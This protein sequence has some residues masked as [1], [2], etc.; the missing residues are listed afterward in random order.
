MRETGR[1]PEHLLALVRQRDADPFAEGRRASS[2]V[3]GHVE[4]APRRGPDELSLRLLDLIVQ[5]AQ[6]PA[7]RVAVVVLHERDVEPRFA[8]VALIPGFE[9]ETPLVAVDAGPK[10]LDLRYGGF[11]DVHQL[12][13]TRSIKYSP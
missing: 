13:R 10:N 8:E 5:A 1:D 12:P 2:E 7:L 11:F 4:D 9:K 3:H 6:R